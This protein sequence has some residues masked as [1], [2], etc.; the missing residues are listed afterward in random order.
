MTEIRTNTVGLE[1]IE[2]VCIRQFN[3]MTFLCLNDDDKASIEKKLE[4]ADIGHLDIEVKVVDADEYK[5]HKAQAES[6]KR[7]KELR[8]KYEA[9][10]EPFMRLYRDMSSVFSDYGMPRLY[11]STTKET[12]M[13]GFTQVQGRKHLSKKKRKQLKN[14]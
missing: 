5:K 11:H 13:K 9:M 1:N 7:E 3:K 6:E 4:N 14:K 10:M 8:D 2:C 12:V